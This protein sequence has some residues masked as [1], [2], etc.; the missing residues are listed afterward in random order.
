MLSLEK[1]RRLRQYMLPK[2][3]ERR[4]VREIGNAPFVSVIVPAWQSRGTL[5]ACLDALQAQTFRDFEVILVNSSPGDGTADLVRSR[6]PE[7]RLDE[8]HVRLLPPQA[9]NR[10]ALLARGR[11]LVFTDP[12]CRAHPSWLERLM[13]AQDLGHEIVAGSLALV[14]PTWYQWAVHLGKCSWLL[15]ALPSGRC[16]VVCSANAAYTRRAFEAAGP[17]D[18]DVCVGDD[19]IS[20]RAVRTGIAPRFHPAAVV[21]QAHTR[22]VAAYVLEFLHRGREVA[23]ARSEAE[24]WSWIGTAGRLL[25]L[26]VSAVGEF[27]RLARRAARARRRAEWFATF[28]LLVVFR[29]ASA[30]GEA[31]ACLGLLAPWRSSPERLKALHS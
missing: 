22:G 26:P 2:D 14:R 20:R 21:A 17:F 24:R 19:L 25:A 4:A 16:A 3:T 18:E 29:A 5:P 9:R 15:E 7:V 10:G 1:T 28:P 8:H 6:F 31:V 11:V 13:A 12:D 23:L 30:C 27:V